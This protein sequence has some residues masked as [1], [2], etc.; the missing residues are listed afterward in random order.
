MRSSG[1]ANKMRIKPATKQL[2]CCDN[3]AAA[4]A[5]GNDDKLP[6]LV[7]KN[8]YVTRNMQICKIVDVFLIK[9]ANKTIHVSPHNVGDYIGS[10]IKQSIIVP[11]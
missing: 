9:R 7:Q 6:T 5:M 4:A 1:L 8:D 2:Q 10:E 11:I 3:L